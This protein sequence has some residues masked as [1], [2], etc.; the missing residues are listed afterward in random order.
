MVCTFFG[1]RD[2][3]YTIREELRGA[4]LK[5]INEEGV[6]KFYV[7]NDGGFDC[8]VQRVLQEITEIRKDI[9]FSVVLSRISENVLSGDQEKSIFPEGMEAA[10]YRFAI[11]KRNEW[12][13]AHSTH[14]IVYVCHESSH[15]AR[16][17]D[18][19]TRKGLRVRNL[20][21]RK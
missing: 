12:M 21:E 6:K 3:P 13:I 5:L 14:A 4:I 9:T 17:L 8:L 15:C 1:H 19:A 2:A 11:A 16:W 10:P 7:G 20:S 18:R